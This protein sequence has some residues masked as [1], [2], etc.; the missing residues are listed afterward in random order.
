MIYLDNAATSFP[1]PRRVIREL[2]KCVK[3]YCGNPGRSAHELSIKSSEKIYETRCALASLLNFPSPENIVFTLNASYALNLA[4]KTTVPK[5]SHVIISDIEHNSVVRPLEGL[6]KA[7]VEYSAFKANEAREKDIEALIRDNTSCIIVNNISNVT[8][9]ENPLETLYK[10]KQKY[11]IKLILDASQSIG[12]RKFD[13]ENA[14]VDVLCA[15]SHKALFGIQGA[16]F[17]VFCDGLSRDSFIEGGSGSESMNPRMPNA[18]PEH[19]EAGTLPTP[20]IASLCEGINFIL[21]TGIEEIEKRL[22]FY[23]DELRERLA[24]IKGVKICGANNGIISFVHEKL[25][26]YVIASELNSLGIAVRSGFHC[27]PFI[28]KRLGTENGGT[29]RASLSYLN[30]KSELDAF[31]KAL[32]TK[33]FVS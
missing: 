14:K 12:H 20:A 6:R 32:K 11:N 17:A 27:A 29:V 19:F 2:L 28:H 18:L 15:P 21:E 33:L 7:G 1:K 22:N 24:S 10:I 3:E 23:T 25:P 13:L 8:G 5:N 16:G 31:Y 9:E 30:Q 26:P 4:I